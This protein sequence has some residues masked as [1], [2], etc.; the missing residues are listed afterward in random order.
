MCHDGFNDFAAQF[1]NLG[2]QY[3]SA[4]LT[5]RLMYADRLRHAGEAYRLHTAV[6]ATPTRVPLITRFGAALVRWGERLQ[7][8]GVALSPVPMKKEVT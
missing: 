2:S 7:A 4:A 3:G 8:I 5:A 1:P 6:G